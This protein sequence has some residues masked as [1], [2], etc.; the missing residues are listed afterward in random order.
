MNVFNGTSAPDVPTLAYAWT[1]DRLAEDMIVDS[2][3]TLDAVMGRRSS[4]SH[5]GGC[6][7]E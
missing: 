5:E 6:P 7:S 2:A 4:G 3:H 1:S